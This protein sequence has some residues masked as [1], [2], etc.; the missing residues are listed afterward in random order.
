[1]KA[2]PPSDP[3]ISVGPQMVFTTKWREMPAPSPF[4]GARPN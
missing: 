1:M 3:Q 4:D 2:T